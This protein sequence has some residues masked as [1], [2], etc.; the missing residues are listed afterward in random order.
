MAKVTFTNEDI[1]RAKLVPPNFYPLVV[2]SFSEE[3][4]GTDGSA[5][6][7]YDIRIEIGPY[8]GVPIRYQISEKAEGMGIEFFEACGNEV[9]A[10]IPFEYDKQVGKKMDGFVQRGEFKGR[11]KNE[12]VAFRKRSGA[13]GSCEYFA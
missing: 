10:G 1:L 12:I 3:Q 6:Y 4:A 7:V 2:K 13:D 11:P 9:K 8:A 5:L